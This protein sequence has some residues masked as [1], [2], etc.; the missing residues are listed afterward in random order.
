[1]DPGPPQRTATQIETYLRRHAYP[2]LGRHQIGAIRRREMQA[3][4]K[5]RTRVL[6][7]RSVERGDRWVTSIFKAAV[8]DRLIAASPCIRIPLLKHDDA[9]IVPRNLS[10]VEARPRGSRG[11]R[12]RGPACH[13]T[14]PAHARPRGRCR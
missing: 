9:E 10:E 1:M 12:L 6:A 14:A 11:P 2:T 8:A 3:W 7:P 5:D 4:V 13:G